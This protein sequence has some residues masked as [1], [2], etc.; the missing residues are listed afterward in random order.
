LNVDGL[1]LS[2]AAVQFFRLF[3]LLEFSVL[4]SYVW[5]VYCS[6]THEFWNRS[7]DPWLLAVS[8]S[9]FKVMNIER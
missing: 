8:H 3:G 2:L 9:G 4:E 7:R 6:W 5:D 1:W